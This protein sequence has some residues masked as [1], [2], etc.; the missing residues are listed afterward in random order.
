MA[1]GTTSKQAVNIPPHGGKLVN[2]LAE[3]SAKREW[4][5]K[6]AH[7]PQLR[8]L[9]RERCDLE[10]LAIGAY[11]PLAGFM[12]KSDYDC[13][14]NDMR[15]ASGLVWSV[16]ITLGVTADQAGALKEGQN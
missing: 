2:R 4:L 5:A 12:G 14:V 11:S 6:A 3:E 13:V 9:L 16:P 10:M 1:E 8:V 7:L 15:L